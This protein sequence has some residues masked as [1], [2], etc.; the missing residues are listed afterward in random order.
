METP[1]V[2]GIDIRPKLLPV[3]RMGTPAELGWTIFFLCAPP[4]A[5][6]VFDERSIRK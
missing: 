3:G 1:T 4:P 2:Q 6:T 5:P